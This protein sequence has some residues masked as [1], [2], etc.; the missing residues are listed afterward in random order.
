LCNKKRTLPRRGGSTTQSGVR[1]RSEGNPSAGAIFIACN[2][3]GTKRR[4][5]GIEKSIPFFC[6]T[7]KE[8][9]PAG[10]VRRRK[11]ACVSAARAIQV[12]EPFFAVGTK[13]TKPHLSRRSPKGED[14]RLDFTEPQALLHILTQRSSSSQTV[15]FLF[16]SI[17]CY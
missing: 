16:F 12:P 1:E 13:K 17:N 11:A 2:K 3:N 6:A 10:V 9:Y 14:G 5:H 7:K 15:F 8:P 4:I